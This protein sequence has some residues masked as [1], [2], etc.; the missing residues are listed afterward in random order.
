MWA[1]FW[2]MRPC[3][4]L[5]MN[6]H[7]HKGTYLTKH[8]SSSI[9]DSHVCVEE[10]LICFCWEVT[11]F[12]EW[13]LCDLEVCVVCSVG[14]KSKG[15]RE[16]VWLPGCYFNTSPLK[17]KG[18]KQHVIKVG[19][20]EQHNL[21]AT[22]SEFLEKFSLFWKSCPHIGKYVGHANCNGSVSETEPLKN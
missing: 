22:N 4:V 13:V 2:C 16:C 10:A 3:R 21:Q 14:G 20:K 1:H 19:K 6:L 12:C 15:K 18:L 9:V 7:A 5:M 8:I 17:S 11:G